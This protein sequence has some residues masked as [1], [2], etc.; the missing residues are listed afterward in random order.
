MAWARLSGGQPSLPLIIPGGT[1]FLALRCVGGLFGCNY[2][3]HCC[4]HVPQGMNSGQSVVE[5][6]H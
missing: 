5:L 1:I 4:K 3:V 6:V 2:F